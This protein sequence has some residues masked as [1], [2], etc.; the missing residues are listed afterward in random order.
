MQYRKLLAT[1]LLVVLGYASIGCGMQKELADAGDAVNRFHGQLDAGNFNT[2][3]NESDSRFRA[4]TPLDQFLPFITAVRTKLGKVESASRKGFFVNYTTSGLQIRV[5]YETK[6]AA[7]DAQEE[8][9]WV[10]NTD[11]LKLLGYHINSNA[12]IIK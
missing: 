5:N 9:V 7:G 6:F 12:L 3:F 10:K 4:A 8:F 11:G 2:I 1:F